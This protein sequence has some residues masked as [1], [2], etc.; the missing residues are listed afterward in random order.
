MQV[1]SKL[2]AQN[3]LVNIKAILTDPLDQQG[4]VQVSIFSAEGF[5]VH[6]DIAVSRVVGVRRDRGL[7]Q[8]CA[9]GPSAEDVP[10]HDTGIPFE[11][12]E[13]VFGSLGQ[14]NVVNGHGW[15]S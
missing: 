5:P 3:D 6:L 11:L 4:P 13:L 9:K 1:L 14:T 2:S 10:L 12:D 7:S 8:G 15:F